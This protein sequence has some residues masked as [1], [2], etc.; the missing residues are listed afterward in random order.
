MPR[1][2]LKESMK[3]GFTAKPFLIIISQFFLLFSANIP[4]SAVEPKISSHTDKWEI[5]RYKGVVVPYHNNEPVILNMYYSIDR[6]NPDYSGHIFKNILK[7]T[8]IDTFLIPVWYKEQKSASPNKMINDAYNRHGD[9][10]S[11]TKKRIDTHLKLFPDAR[12]MIRLPLTLP[13]AWLDK[14]P[15]EMVHGEDGKIAY[16]YYTP[17]SYFSDKSFQYFGNNLKKMVSFLEKEYPGKIIGYLLTTGWSGEWNRFKSRAINGGCSL[18]DY[19]P[20]AEKGFQK[21][22]KNKFK[23][24]NAL[25][26]ACNKKYKSFEEIKIPSEAD[27]TGST[28]DYF[29]TPQEAVLTK[30]YME[31]LSSI[32]AERIIQLCKTVKEIAPGRLCGTS[33]AYWFGNHQGGIRGIGF[34][35]PHLMYEKLGKS[36]YYDFTFSPPLKGFAGLSHPVKTHAILGTIDSF[37]KT[38][39]T[40]CE[41]PTHLNLYLPDVISSLIRSTYKIGKPITDLD[42]HYKKIAEEAAKRDPKYKWAPDYHKNYGKMFARMEKGKEKFIIEPSYR[43]PRNMQQSKANLKRI[44]LN[45]VTQP[46]GGLW[47]WD[48]EG[49]KRQCEDGVAYNHPQIQET[50]YKISNV[51]KKAAKL[52]RTPRHEM[53]IIH[54]HDSHYY[55]NEGRN[56]YRFLRSAILT[57]VLPLGSCGIPYTDFYLEDLEKIRNLDQYK[58]FI[59]PNAHFVS[60]KQRLWIDK[61]LKKDGRVLVW[62]FGSGYLTDG[63][64]SVENMERLTGIKF[65]ELDNKEILACRVLGQKS[66]VTSGIGEGVRFGQF[67]L[68]NRN[69]AS[70]KK[71]L[72]DPPLVQPHFV[73]TDKGADILGLSYRRFEPVFG[74]KSFKSWTSVYLPTGPMPVRLLKNIAKIA[75]VNVYTDSDDIQVFATKSLIGLYSYPSVVGNREITLPGDILE[76]KE[77]FTG[78]V[79]AVHNNKISIN[80][81]GSQAYFLF[82]TRTR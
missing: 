31:A 56:N 7:N 12:F 46:I 30:S 55:Y 39:I 72:E 71:R 75:K 67:S 60:E 2:I 3:K 29:K 20:V 79:Y 66:P 81:N 37:N 54:S 50:L 19:S 26:S 17:F 40:E 48:D 36:K 82:V 34:L 77:Y 44:A 45:V 33:Y 8:G 76:V 62:F 47:W 27:F 25:N 15:E 52:N 18:A 24:I 14:F 9:F 65:K 61:N 64:K 16:N 69:P 63:S 23:D 5:K 58:V 38:Y 6:F 80:F 68:L 73:I 22:L 49:V 21:Y 41:H 28:G 13:K 10:Y 53:A 43:V 1:I 59:F 70:K 57:N 51:F 32:L 11:I 4:C 42:L 35:T 74:A 78:K